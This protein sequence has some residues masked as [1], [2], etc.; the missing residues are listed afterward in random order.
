MHL[1]CKYVWQLV[2]CVQVMLSHLHDPARRGPPH[3][4]SRVQDTAME[5]GR[6]EESAYFAVSYFCE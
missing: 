4:V 1:N 6:A 3:C 2:W 5:P